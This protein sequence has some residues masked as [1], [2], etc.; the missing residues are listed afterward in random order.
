[1]RP[2]K[3]GRKALFAAFAVLV[4]SL[5]PALAQAQAASKPNIIMIMH[6]GSNSKDGGLTHSVCRP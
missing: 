1:M 2:L 3:G 6:T 5:L 4:S